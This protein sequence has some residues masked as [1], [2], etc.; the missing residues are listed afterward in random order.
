MPEVWDRELRHG[1]GHECL[2]PDDTVVFPQGSRCDEDLSADLRRVQPFGRVPGRTSRGGDDPVQA[3]G[4]PSVFCV[5]EEQVLR[6]DADADEG[7]L[8]PGCPEIARGSGKEPPG[9]DSGQAEEDE[10]L[11][12]E[13]CMAPD[14]VHP[15]WRP[16]TASGGGTVP[17]DVDSAQVEDHEGKA[18]T[19]IT[20][21]YHPL[22][23][24][25]CSSISEGTLST[26]AGASA[27][28]PQARNTSRMPMIPVDHLEVAFA[29]DTHPLAFRG[30]GDQVQEGPDR[31]RGA[32]VWSSS[33]SAERELLPHA[34]DEFVSVPISTWN[35]AGAGKK[36]SQRD[37]HY[38]VR[39]R[40]SGRPG[41]S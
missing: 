39:G 36:K 2:P 20:G 24:Q 14:P 34:R 25:D 32:G 30:G 3:V 27:A 31:Q 28:P 21:R 12:G 9:A 18:K 7:R 6:P 5:R 8:L 23:Q 4:P 35:L 1:Q 22:M 15:L 19:N 33:S 29:A 11:P 10:G 26:D 41:V 38:S 40:H 17:P 13:K 16:A 37:H